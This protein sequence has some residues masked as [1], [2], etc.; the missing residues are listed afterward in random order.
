MNTSIPFSKPVPFSVTSQ[1]ECGKPD[2]SGNGKKI[3]IVD[4]SIVIVKTLSAKLR[5]NG[6]TVTTA[7][8]GSEAVSTVR[9][10][11]PDAILLDIN[12]PPDVAHGGGVAWDGFLIMSW[13]RRMDEAVNTPV[14]I[15][16][17]ADQETRDRCLKAGVAG[18]FQKPINHDELLAVLERLIGNNKGANE[19][20]KGRK[21]VL[22]VDDEQDWRFMAGLYMKDAGLEVLT[23][24]GG[25]EALEKIRGARPDLVL[26]D[27]NLAGESGLEVLK[28]LKEQ[29]P[30]L[31]VILYTGME[32]DKESVEGMLRLG[33]YRYVR[34]STMGEMLKAVQ[35]AFA[36]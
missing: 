32:H 33:A 31:R 8:E 36:A 30:S 25:T 6:Y 12:F 29:Q 13:L 23:A 28:R 21:T 17:G 14:I 1:P 11:R 19:S 24:A 9:R 15:I 34:K 10:E 35:D 27:L 7:M 26:L 18:Y 20:P 5:M 22:L 16:T 3:L 4:D 2:G